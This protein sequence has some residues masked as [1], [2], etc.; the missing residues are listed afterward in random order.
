MIKEILASLAIGGSLT[1]KM[2]VFNIKTE[3]AKL[4]GCAS[5][6]TRK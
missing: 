2:D 5:S 6:F 4:G 3:A 1:D